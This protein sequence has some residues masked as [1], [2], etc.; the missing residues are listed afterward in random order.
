MTNFRTCPA[1]ACRSTGWQND[2]TK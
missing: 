2:F 1:A